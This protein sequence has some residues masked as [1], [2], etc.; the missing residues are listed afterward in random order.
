MKR[1][2]DEKNASMDRMKRKLEEARAAGRGAGAADR[3]QAARLTDRR[4]FKPF[5]R[6]TDHVMDHLH[7]LDHLHVFLSSARF[8]SSTRFLII[9]TI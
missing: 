7:D 6:Q 8:R 4:A 9:C 2:L 3:N 5:A 1:L